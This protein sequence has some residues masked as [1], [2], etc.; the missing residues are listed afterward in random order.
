MII[1]IQIKPGLIEDRID[2]HIK[3]ATFSIG[4]CMSGMVK[5]V[6]HRKKRGGCKLNKKNAGK[7]NYK[8]RPLRAFGKQAHDFIVYWIGSIAYRTTILQ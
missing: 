3:D 4:K 6:I 7:G 8:Y 1:R 2:R 5:R